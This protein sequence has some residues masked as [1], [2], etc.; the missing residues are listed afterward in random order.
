[1]IRHEHPGDQTVIAAIHRTAL[2]ED[3]AAL[4]DALRQTK[5]AAM[6]LVAERCHTVVGHLLFSRL[7]APMRALALA[8]LSV[9]PDY[10]RQGIGSDLVKTG[11][12]QAVKDGWEAVFVLGEPA[13]YARFG[14]DLEAAR[15][16]CCPYSG[17]GF[18]V[19]QLGSKPLPTSG[20][21]IYPS[22]FRMFG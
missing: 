1:M 13:F 20:E 22:P 5:D 15:A 16:F 17:G 21:I 19:L 10:Q 7:R 6:S 4:V 8:P 2:G 9:L 12:D 18:M 14:F 11:L 3:E